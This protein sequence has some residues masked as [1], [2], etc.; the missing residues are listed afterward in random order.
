LRSAF[1]PSDID[2]DVVFDRYLGAAGDLDTLQSFIRAHARA[3]SK[4][5][6]IWI[7]PRDQRPI[8]IE[9]PGSLRLAIVAAANERGPL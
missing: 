3:W 6:R 9:K 8:D 4:R 5:L 2:A 1:G 7:T